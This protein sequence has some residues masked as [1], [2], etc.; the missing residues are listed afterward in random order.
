MTP[1]KITR[2]SFDS[3]RVR[4]VMALRESTGTSEMTDGVAYCDA[5]AQLL[6]PYMVAFCPRFALQPYYSHF[7]AYLRAQALLSTGIPGSHFQGIEAADDS[8]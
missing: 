6:Q 2:A 7:V 8:Q 3:F 1:F 5:G 4:I